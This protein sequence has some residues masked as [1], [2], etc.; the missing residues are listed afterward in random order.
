VDGDFDDRDNVSVAPRSTD[1]GAAR[2]CAGVS[3]EVSDRIAHHPTLP[4]WTD[5]RVRCER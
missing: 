4:G 3:W 5:R 1:W 2:D